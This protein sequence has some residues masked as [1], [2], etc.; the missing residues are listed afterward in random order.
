MFQRRRSSIKNTEDSHAFFINRSRNLI[1]VTRN[2]IV[3]LNDMSTE[4]RQMTERLFTEE[5]DTKNCSTRRRSSV[6]YETKLIIQRRL[7]KELIQYHG[8]KETST[9][10]LENVSNSA[11]F[12]TFRNKD[13]LRPSTRAL[14]GVNMN[15]LEING[16]SNVDQLRRNCGHKG[17]KPL[18]T[19]NQDSDTDGLPINTSNQKS[20]QK[21]RGPNF[22]GY[23]PPT[24]SYKYTKGEDQIAVNEQENGISCDTHVFGSSR[25]R[26]RRPTL[27]LPQIHL[28]GLI[29]DNLRTTK[30]NQT[31]QS[32][33]QFNKTSWNETPYRC[34]LN[35]KIL[36]K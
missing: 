4:I 32:G 16:K 11:D 35:Q 24:P 8:S 10:N 34:C 19:I 2:H 1:S 29:T 13:S 7:S 15:F 31:S 3:K 28:S 22:F 20:T 26:S 12:R 9:D 33:F 14:D 27:H 21:K 18:T 5:N 23:K 30:I 17:N 6:K 36:R 25:Y